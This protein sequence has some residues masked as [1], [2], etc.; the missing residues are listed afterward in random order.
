MNLSIARSF[1]GIVASVLTC[2]SLYAEVIFGDLADTT[3]VQNNTLNPPEAAVMRVGATNSVNPGG[4]NVLL[5]FQLPDFGA[6]ANPF[7]TADFGLN[8]FSVNGPPSFNVDLYGL[9][10]QSSATLILGNGVLATD[11]F[12]ESNTVDAN[13]T[14]IQLDFTIPGAGASPGF[15]NTNATGDANL[16]TYLNTLYGS[17]TGAG[18]YVVLRANPDVDAGNAIVGYNYSAADAGATANATGPGTAFDPVIT[19][20]AVPEPSSA[21]LLLGAL[22]ML[23]FVGCWRCRSVS[24][25]NR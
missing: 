4:A 25:R 10:I 3:L 7:V 14:L 20:A 8:L 5:V 24:E 6:V 12:Y 1:L 13:A 21:V 11:R 18:Q 15:K 19:Y 2:G 23:G 16:L 17:G 22:G 9:G